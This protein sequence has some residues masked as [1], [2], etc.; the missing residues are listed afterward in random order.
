MLG[1]RL[2]TAADVPQLTFT[3][4]VI[5]ETLRLYPPAW[6]ISRRAS[7]EV[8]VGGYRVPEGSNIIVSQW[9]THRDARYFPEPATFRPDRWTEDFERALPRF[10][11]FP[12]GGGPRSC[13]GN[14]F[15]LMEAAVLLAAVA[16]RY[17]IS[18][19]PGATVEPMPSITLRPAN[20]VQ[21]QL[22]SR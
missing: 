9:V 17:K 14:N 5:R 13:I 10:A 7:E 11:Y 8:D 21:V 4:K 16:Q 3:N 22:K 6:V 1:G 12:F 19:A 15:A 18:M 2:P 20:G